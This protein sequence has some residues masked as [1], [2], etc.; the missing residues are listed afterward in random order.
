MELS[1][2]QDQGPLL[3][4]NRANRGKAARL[5]ASNLPNLPTES[6]NGRGKFHLFS[7]V[8]DIKTDEELA[9]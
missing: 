1:K 9:V 7:K 5:T 3:P 8:F 4:K 6:P 2:R